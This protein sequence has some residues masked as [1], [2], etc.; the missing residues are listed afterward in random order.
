MNLFSNLQAA[1]SQAIA[2]Q[3]PIA[4]P[5]CLPSASLQNAQTACTLAQA[6]QEAASGFGGYRGLG[7]TD[8]YAAGIA[9]DPCGW[10]QL[11]ACAQPPKPSMVRLTPPPAAPVV[12]AAPV[13][14][15][16]IPVVAPPPSNKNL[17]IG[18]IIAVLAVG[19][20]AYYFSER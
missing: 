14:T 12:V 6:G 19:G 2:Q 18:G 20:I 17:I 13:A 11:P 10:A 3:A 5:A 16:M 9:Q 7:D 1:V 15:P 8:P 4:K